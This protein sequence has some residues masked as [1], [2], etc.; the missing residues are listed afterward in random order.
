MS[1]AKK[2]PLCKIL[3]TLDEDPKVQFFPWEL[4]VR[5]VAASMCK[6]ITPRGLLSVLLT[7]EQWNAY[8]ANIT[9]DPQGLVVIAPRFAPPNFIDINDTMSSVELFVATASNTKLLEWS[10]HEEALKTAITESLG[11]VVRQIVKHSVDGFTLMSIQ[12]IMARVRARYGRMRPNTKLD[13][14]ERMTARLAS[15][16]LLDTH[17]STLRENFTI[18]AI[19]GQTIAEDKKVQYLRA[20]LS[21][22]ALIDAALS[23]YTFAH[24]DE[25]TQTFEGMVTYIEDHL[26]N[27]QAA[28]KIAAQATANVMASEVYLT[29]E[30]E[31]KTL[32]EQQIKHSQDQNDQNRK[33][34]KGGKGKGKN[35]KNKKGNRNDSDKS[36]PASDRPLKYCHA[37]GT[38]HT[39]T[40]Q[41]CKLMA[42]DK[43]RFNA[44]MRAAKDSTH[45]PGGSTKVLGKPAE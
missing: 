13:L 41:K 25:T 34:R 22:H 18:S 9:V 28:S 16:D 7:D 21:G 44:A 15:T 36:N 12:D 11:S 17:V 20:S 39:H 42:G 24:P 5:N 3:L 14:K 43:S 19:G 40:S 26:P 38:Q 33:R 23:Q 32:K 29:L 30:A 2:Q 6:T 37:H 10:T 27:L 8:S 1:I 45:P 35:K 31:N 4:E